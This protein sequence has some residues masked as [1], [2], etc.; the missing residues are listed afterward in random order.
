MLN[1]IIT[2]WP[3]KKLKKMCRK[4]RFTKV[5][6][7]IFVYVYWIENKSSFVLCSSCSRIEK[8]SSANNSVKHLF[9]LPCT[10]FFHC[11]YL[12]DVMFCLYMVF[13]F[14]NIKI[15]AKFF[16]NILSKAILN[17]NKN[18]DILITFCSKTSYCFYLLA[19]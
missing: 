7:I 14:L 16:Q 13:I 2:R 11:S 1:G 4:V 15:W 12:Q 6:F 3:T 17:W 9:I 8:L 19:D 18:N 5:V 10:W